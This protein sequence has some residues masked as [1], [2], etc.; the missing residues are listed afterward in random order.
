[1]LLSRRMLLRHGLVL[2]GLTSSAALP[3]HSALAAPRRPAWHRPPRPLVVLDPG[4]GGKDPGCIGHHGTHEKHVSLAIG[5]ELRR[6]LLAHRV[7]RVAM[8][9]ASD[10]F[11]PL[12]QRVAIAERHKAALFVSIHENSCPSRL[13]H[14]ASV[15]TFA[16]HASDPDSARLAARENRADR[17]GGPKFKHYS[18]QVSRILR[19]LLSRE[20]R[21]H[22]AE[23]QHDLVHRLDHRVGLVQRPARHAH[24]VVLEATN[25]PSVLIETGFL[26][27]PHEE[28]LL[29]TRHHQIVVATSIRSAISR[30]LVE[31][32]KTLRL[33]R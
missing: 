28:K 29:R 21:I 33:T 17:F 13:V 4:H 22:S 6:Q 16:T 9:R 5:L 23:L 31:D 1:M 15:Y 12:E 10:V 7:C 32:A 14:G 18:P 27:N 26:S 19:S 20:T 2:A 8:T 24:F 3:G 11:I 30:Y 25:I